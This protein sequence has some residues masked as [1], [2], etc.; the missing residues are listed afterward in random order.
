MQIE[1]LKALFAWRDHASPLPLQAF[2]WGGG[3]EGGERAGRARCSQ[4]RTAE[5]SVPRD[6]VCWC[7]LRALWEAV[8]SRAY[9]ERP[10]CG[11]S[12][13]LGDKTH[14]S[15][16]LHFLEALQAC[17]SC[18]GSKRDRRE[19]QDTM[20]PNTSVTQSGCRGVIKFALICC[21]PLPA[22]PPRQSLL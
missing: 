13:D 9:G 2:F 19:S 20:S 17:R 10:F 7:C 6:L 22:L 16:L 5:R 3:G 4:A 1:F 8:R 14:P 18:A 21:L 12:S 11:S 15:I